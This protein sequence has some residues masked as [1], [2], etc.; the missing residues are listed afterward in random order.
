MTEN[1]SSEKIVYL[2]EMRVYDYL[3][4]YLKKECPTRT[5]KNQ[6][7]IANALFTDS[8]NSKN[9]LDYIP[10][11][12]TIQRALKIMKNQKVIFQD[13]QGS[14]YIFRKFKDIDT[15][16]YR[17]EQISSHLVSYTLES[18]LERRHIFI[19]KQAFPLTKATLIFRI[20]PNAHDYVIRLLDELP[21]DMFWGI[22]SQGEYIYLM[23]NED[24]PFFKD[25]YKA[26]A[27]FKV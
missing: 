20:S 1:S 21:K 22:S 7:E 4:E 26:F 27:S 16:E 15:N 25:V 3:Y 12:S 24:Y 13:F 2:R 23:F 19:C 9:P 14:K 10:N 6:T 5:F 18:L 11:Q 8:Q 17:F